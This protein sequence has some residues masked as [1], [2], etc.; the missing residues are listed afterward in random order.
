[1][2]LAAL[3]S[4]GKDSLYALSKASEE[5]DVK[6]LISIDAESDSELLDTDNL[7]LVKLQS[8]AMGIP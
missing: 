6:Y 5:H 4:G 7:D 1:M 8:E 3:V 2:K